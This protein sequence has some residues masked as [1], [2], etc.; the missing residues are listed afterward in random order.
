MMRSSDSALFVRM[1]GREHQV[2]GAGEMDRGLHALAVANLANQD[3]IG[4]RAHHAAQGAGVGLGVEP[5]LA[6]V[7]DRAFVRVQ[8]LDRVL[9]GDDVVGGVLVAVVD[10]RRQAGGLARTGGAHHE[11]EAALEHDEIGEGLGQAQVLQAWH[12][13]GDIAQHHGGD[14]PAA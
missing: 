5:D 7:H 10:H 3:H 1:H 2:A 14:S 4:R 12:I 13:R 9:D 11:H 6:L 8:E